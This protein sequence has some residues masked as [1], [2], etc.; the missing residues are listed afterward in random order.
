MHAF[1]NLNLYIL[2]FI[3]QKFSATTKYGGYINSVFIV[4][5]QRESIDQSPCH[6]FLGSFNFY[7]VTIKRHLAAQN[8][9]HKLYKAQN[10]GV[11]YSLLNKQTAGLC[12]N[13]RLKAP[14]KWHYINPFGSNEG[15]SYD[16][17]FLLPLQ[18]G[19]NWCTNWNGAKPLFNH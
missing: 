4:T 2:E 18:I 8:I 14:Y 12:V 13:C 9:V 1:R 5:L 16:W 7:V 10:S 17:E 6:M 3:A 19:S 15:V 11:I